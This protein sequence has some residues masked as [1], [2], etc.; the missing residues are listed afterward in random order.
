MP[1]LGEDV[2]VNR[3]SEKMKAE[4]VSLSTH[5]KVFAAKTKIVKHLVEDQDVSVNKD[6]FSMNL[7]NAFHKHLIHVY[8]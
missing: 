8:L 3:D 5:V 7:E 1:A 4:D 2:V 6:L